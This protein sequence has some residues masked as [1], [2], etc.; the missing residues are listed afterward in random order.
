[1]WWPLQSAST[2]AAFKKLVANGQ[3]EFV[4]AGALP[5]HLHS[6]LRSLFLP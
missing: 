3:L 1:M 2:Q 6:H 5:S 4:G